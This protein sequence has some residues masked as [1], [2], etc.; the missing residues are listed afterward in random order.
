[1]LI[2][3]GREFMNAIDYIAATNMNPNKRVGLVHG[4]FKYT[5][6]PIMRMAAAVMKQHKVVNNR[7]GSGTLNLTKYSDSAR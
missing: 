2:A 7:R 4:I 6:G 1:M 3:S 5:V